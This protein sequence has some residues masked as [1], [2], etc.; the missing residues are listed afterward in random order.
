[1]IG[2]AAAL[3]WWLTQAPIG[4]AWVDVLEIAHP[5]WAQSYV[6]ANRD[7]VARITFEDGRSVEPL[8]ISFRVDLPD[9]GTN[10]R[11]DMRVTLDNVGAEVW[12]ALELA[13]TQPQYPL[14][15]TW[16]VYLRS[17]PSAPQASP[18]RLAAVNVTATQEAIE[19]S[20]QRADVINRRWPRKVYTS[21]RWPGLVR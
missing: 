12:S 19:L 4:D 3:Q 11:Q 1:M 18:L 14:Q 15:V 10:G 6:I 16:R 5:A 8:A 17:I 13:Q 2:P 9:A 7:D 20:A 21:E